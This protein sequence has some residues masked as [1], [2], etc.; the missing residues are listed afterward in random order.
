MILSADP[1]C[2]GRVS[3]ATSTADAANIGRAFC[4]GQPVA[5]PCAVRS[6]SPAQLEQGLDGPQA[7]PLPSDPNLTFYAVALP[8]PAGRYPALG[9]EDSACVC[10]NGDFGTCHLQVPFS[11][12]ALLSRHIPVR[13]L[14]LM[15]QGRGVTE[16]PANRSPTVRRRELG[17]LLRALRQGRG[18]TAEEVAEQLLVPPR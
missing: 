18:W 9:L 5:G 14:H 10:F 17:A 15:P 2:D 7:P 8:P 6:L 1:P 3:G 12:Y 4:S 16:V 11:S 13:S